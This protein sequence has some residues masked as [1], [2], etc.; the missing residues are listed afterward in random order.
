VQ[1]FFPETVAIK[2]VE[3]FKAEQKPETKTS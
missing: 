3:T 1:K 2:F